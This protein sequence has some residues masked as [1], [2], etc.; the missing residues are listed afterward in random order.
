[1]ISKL[2]I[3]KNYILLIG[4]LFFT[5]SSCTKDKA[6]LKT[7]GLID[8]PFILSVEGKMSAQVINAID[9]ANQVNVLKNGAVILFKT[10]SN[11][12]GKIQ[13]VEITTVGQDHTLKFN[14][15]MY[16]DA[17]TQSLNKPAVA[18]PGTWLYDFDTG[19]TAIDATTDIN[20]ST[21]ADVN[22]FSIIPANGAKLY[23]YSN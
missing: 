16:D 20:F 8:R 22:F 2:L 11:K 12:F 13:I 9:L 18:L 17:G 23:L 15:I 6:P 14:L 5:I 19:S 7:F 4:L 21:G 1:M 10:N 3:M